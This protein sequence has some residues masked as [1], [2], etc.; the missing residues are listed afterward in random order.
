MVV[1][2]AMVV[3]LVLALAVALVPVTVVVLVL[4]LAVALVLALAPVVGSRATLVRLPT[5]QYGSTQ[6]D[7]IV[8]GMGSRI[9]TIF[10]GSSRGSSGAGSVSGF[11][12]RGSRRSRHGSGY[13]DHRDWSTNYL[14]Y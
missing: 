5:F 8:G 4:A 10:S 3:A 9:N 7:R 14:R 11:G 12:G 13:E 1:V 6:A 2:A